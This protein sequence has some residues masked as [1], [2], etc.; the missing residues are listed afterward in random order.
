MNYDTFDKAEELL[1]NK[2]TSEL[3]DNERMLLSKQFGSIEQAEE[4]RE[5][6]LLAREELSPANNNIPE[7]DAF[8]AVRVKARLRELKHKQESCQGWWQSLIH[9]LNYRVRLYQSG[10]AMLAVV[11]VM[12][13]LTN[14]PGTSQND[15]KDTLF[16]DSSAVRSI[17]ISDT[18]ARDH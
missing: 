14:Q 10:I 2:E 17:D 1:L 16:A 15:T 3:T 5:F 13:F 8:T 18:V 7:P 9:L 12:F 6:L 4:Y 11:A